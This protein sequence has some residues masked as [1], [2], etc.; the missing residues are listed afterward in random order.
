MTD[1]TLNAF[2]EASLRAGTSRSEIENALME[3]GWSRD[4]ITDGLTSFADVD[5]VVPVPMPK[6]QVSARDAFLYL[7]MFGTLYLSAFHLGNLFFQ[8]VNLAFPD[9]LQERVE[10]FY[11]QIR[12]ATSTIVVAFPVF[13]YLSYRTLKE[14]KSDPTRRTSAVRR[15]LTYLTLFIAA[16]VMAGDLISLVYNMLSGGLTVRFILKTI[17]VG[18]IAGVV[19][20]YYLWSTKADGEV[21]AQ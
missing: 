8:F 14:V 9:E 4:Q 17:I 20:G 5:F 16:S 6:A 13:L 21:L 18:L 12:W 1:T 19:F 3:A 11:E 7:V 15:W 10:F 2:V